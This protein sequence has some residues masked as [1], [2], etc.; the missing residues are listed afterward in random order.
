MYLYHLFY[1]LAFIP[2]LLLVLGLGL[3]PLIFCFQTYF[4]LLTH[5]ADLWIRFLL[6]IL[7]ILGLTSLALIWVWALIWVLSTLLTSVYFVVGVIAICVI[8]LF[9]LILLSSL[10]LFALN[11]PLS[12]QALISFSPTLLF[13]AQFVSSTSEFI[14]SSFSL[15]TLR[16]LFLT[17]LFVFLLL[18]LRT[19]IGNQILLFLSNRHYYS[20]WFQH[21][22]NP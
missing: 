22:C 21:T 4:V 20:C 7:V 14:H 18:H 3:E 17:L 13:V 19:I 12:Y 5:L 9:S 1:L 15:F 2:L 16:F 11:W 10:I 8:L 6:V